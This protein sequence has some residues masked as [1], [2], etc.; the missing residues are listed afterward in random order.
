MHCIS[1]CTKLLV[2]TIQ[3]AH[4]YIRTPVHISTEGT[5]ILPTVVDGEVRAAHSIVPR[6]KMGLLYL[7]FDLSPSLTS[8][9]ATGIIHLNYEGQGPRYLQQPSSYRPTVG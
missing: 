4:M 8:F 6:Q 7:Y 5:A 3:Y 9:P 2:V 1:T